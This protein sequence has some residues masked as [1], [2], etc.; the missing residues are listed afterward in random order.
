[1][2]HSCNYSSRWR[3]FSRFRQQNRIEHAVC[4]QFG[5]LDQAARCIRGT[6][7]LWGSDQLA[8][9]AVLCWVQLSTRPS[10]ASR[11]EQ[12]CRK[13]ASSMIQT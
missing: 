9:L 10:M 8:A 11:R 12:C 1:V 6:G 5:P 13:H 2:P 3:G 7:V 4:G